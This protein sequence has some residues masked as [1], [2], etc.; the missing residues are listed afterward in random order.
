MSKYYV[1]VRPLDRYDIPG[2]KSR[3]LTTEKWAEISQ[4]IPVGRG[5]D[6][7]IEGAP[8]ET[9]AVY[10]SEEILKRSLVYFT[11]VETDTQ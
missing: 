4:K 9:V 6:L 5:F 8:G 2:I 1:I 7:P 10:I 3:A 11:R